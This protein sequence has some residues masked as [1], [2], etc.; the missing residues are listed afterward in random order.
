MAGPIS[1]DA[2]EAIRAGLEFR[3]DWEA[4]PI[5]VDDLR[6][7]LARIDA[8]KWRLMGDKPT[9]PCAVVMFMG[10]L[11]ESYP[12]MLPRPGE[13]RD[14]RL[15]LGWFD[16][17]EFFVNGTGHSAFDHFSEEAEHPTA[18]RRVSIP[19]PPEPSP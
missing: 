15:E 16:G 11:G 9:E 1:D 17:A 3:S 4:V 5:N 14:E 10:R 7:L 18:W 12:D 8:E 13:V 19:S 2:M 6:A